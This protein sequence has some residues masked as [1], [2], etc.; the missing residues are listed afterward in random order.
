MASGGRVTAGGTVVEGSG[1]ADVAG[2]LGGVVPGLVVIMGVVAVAAGVTGEPLHEKMLTDTINRAS[3]ASSGR[4]TEGPPSP[5][6][7]S[8]SDRPTN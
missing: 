1:V 5:V 6:A 7:G 4:F 2:G 3:A 8:R